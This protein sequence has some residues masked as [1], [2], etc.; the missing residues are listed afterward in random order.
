M[1]KKI[2][3]LGS[4]G[5]LGRALSA[6]LASYTSVLTPTRR[7]L[8]LT[9]F[10]ALERYVTAH[11]PDVIINAAALTG[12]EA[13]EQDQQLADQL[14]AEL[15]SK[16][17]QLS[18]SLDAL[19]VHFSG[20]DVYGEV[21]PQHGQAQVNESSSTDPRSYYARNKL[22]GD[23]AVQTLGGEYLIFRLS[24]L[25]CR[26][27]LNVKCERSPLL[28][29]APTSAMYVATTVVRSMERV[30]RRVIRFHPGIYNLSAKGDADWQEFYRELTTLRQNYRRLN[31]SPKLIEC[32]SRIS[33]E[34]VEN[35]FCILVPSWQAQ[36]KTFLELSKAPEA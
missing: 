23:V 21:L 11:R 15:P 19:L 36:L 20:L 34:K 26:N 18:Q 4:T 32:G 5:M 24:G 28:L 8:N 7:E 9:D 31:G 35:A 13:C 17:A 3:L 16:L 27:D 14:N 33:V 22:A 1:A 12:I 29:G 30:F 10:D 2:L 6:A 25:Y